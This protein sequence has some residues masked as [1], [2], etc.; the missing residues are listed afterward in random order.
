MEGECWKSI[1]IGDTE[2]QTKDGKCRKQQL[3][4]WKD[5]ANDG[6]AGKKDKERD[7]TITQ[8]WCWKSKVLLIETMQQKYIGNSQREEATNAFIVS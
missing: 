4:E 3:S 2:G 5:I 7:W 6:G 8:R 1:K